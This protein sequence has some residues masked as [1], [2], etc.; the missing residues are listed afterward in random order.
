MHTLF[1]EVVEIRNALAYFVAASET[2]ERKHK[3][4]TGGTCRFFRRLSR[5]RRRFGLRRGL[6]RGRGCLL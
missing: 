5:R 2:E 1:I 6:R 3:I 4:V